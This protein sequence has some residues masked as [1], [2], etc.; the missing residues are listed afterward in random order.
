[1]NDHAYVER[2]TEIIRRN[3]KHIEDAVNATDGVTIPVKPEYGFCMII[4]VEGTGV[5][6]QEIACELLTHNIA[7]ITDDGL[8]DVGAPTY[9]RLN[10]SHPDI[11][12]IETFR[13]AL[14]LAIAAAKTGKYR[15]AVIDFFAKTETERGKKIIEILK[16]QA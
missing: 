10:Y 15:Q 9:I 12:C 3:Y 8:G 2:S 16:K 4:D 7:A 14:P 1:M 11:E 6:A 13:K 5:S